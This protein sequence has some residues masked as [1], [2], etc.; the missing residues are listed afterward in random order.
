MK[1]EE[2][3]GDL[4]SGKLELEG[5]NSKLKEEMIKLKQEMRRKDDLL[6]TSDKISVGLYNIMMRAKGELE[7]CERLAPALRSVSSSYSTSS[8]TDVD[9]EEEDEEGSDEDEE[10]S[11]EHGEEE[12]SVSKEESEGSELEEVGREEE[13]E[14]LFG[15][16]TIIVRD[17]VT[18][19]SEQL[20]ALDNEEEEVYDQAIAGNVQV[21]QGALRREEGLPIGQGEPGV[22]LEGGE[23]RHQA[24]NREDPKEGKDSTSVDIV[25]VEKGVD[26]D[27]RESIS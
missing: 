7:E 2:E 18:S 5:E 21:E 6:A 10:E 11:Q 26:E 1:L 17:V 25:Q 19:D 9:V 14:A 16:E 20:E 3:I 22:E 4:R 27:G 8:E 12:S 13:G 24:E 23:G 15:D